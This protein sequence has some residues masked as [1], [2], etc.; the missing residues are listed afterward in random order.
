MATD[1]ASCEPDLSRAP[2]DPAGA[3]A[4][5]AVTE[6][7][8]LRERCRCGLGVVPRS[9]PDTP[10][11]MPGA[12]LECP[13]TS[14][15]FHFLLRGTPSQGCPLPSGVPPPWCASSPGCPFLPPG[16]ALR[17]SLP[18]GACP[19]GQKRIRVARRYPRRPRGARSPSVLLEAPRM[20]PWGPLC[21]LLGCS[22]RISTPIVQLRQAPSKC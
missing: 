9:P 7:P 15:G 20:R 14:S 5:A 18:W 8:G 22:R 3:T 1:G 16:C 19:Q 12:S 6:F 21:P 17:M 4:E 10:R 11:G 2:D 13:L